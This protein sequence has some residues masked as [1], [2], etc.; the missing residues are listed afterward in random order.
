MASL[1]PVR[2]TY[3][4]LPE[5]QRRHQ[6]QRQ[7]RHLVAE[8][9]R[10]IGAE[11]F[12]EVRHAADMRRID[13]SLYPRLAAEIRGTTVMITVAWAIGGSSVSETSIRT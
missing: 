7:L 2:G 5:Q 12:C 11:E 9:G 8:L 13:G 4:L 1:Q 6:G 3:D 10:R